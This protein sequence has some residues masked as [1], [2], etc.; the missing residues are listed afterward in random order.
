MPTLV[1]VW[2]VTTHAY[3]KRQKHSRKRVGAA[4][5]LSI[6]D[7]QHFLSTGLERC[8][9]DLSAVLLDRSRA[10]HVFAWGLLE[11]TEEIDS[12]L[13]SKTLQRRILLEFNNYLPLLHFTLKHVVSLQ[14]PHKAFHVG[15][16]PT[17]NTRVFLLRPD[18]V[19]RVLMSQPALG[20]GTVGDQVHASYPEFARANMS[21]IGFEM[22]VP[23]CIL[24]AFGQWTD[25]SLPAEAKWPSA[26][27]QQL[28]DDTRVRVCR[29]RE[30]AFEMEN[31]VVKLDT[32]GQE[33]MGPQGFRNM[34]S[35]ICSWA[36]MLLEGKQFDMDVERFQMELAV[37]SCEAQAKLLED[38]AAGHVMEDN[39][40]SSGKRFNIVFLLQ[41][42]WFAFDLKS[43]SS[44]RRALLQAC[45][46]MFPGTKHTFLQ[47]AIQSE[48]LPLPSQSVLAQ[49]RFFL[50]MALM[51]KMRQKH[52]NIYHPLQNSPH[53]C[54]AHGAMY[55]MADSS[56]QGGVNWL[57]IEYVRIDH[58]A[59][60]AS[61]KAAAQLTGVASRL[62]QAERAGLPILE[63]ELDVEMSCATML[64]SNLER[65]PMVPVGLGSGR[66]S[67]WHELHALYHSF[68]LEC[69]DP[70][71]LAELASSVISMT[72]DRGT[73]AGFAQAHPVPFNMFFPHFQQAH[74]V[75][76]EDA[77]GLAVEGPVGEDDEADEAPANPPVPANDAP[78]SLRSALPTPGCLH[79]VHNATRNMLRAMPHF[80]SK[81]KAGFAAVVD[82]LHSSYTRQRFVATCLT[83][84]EAHA[85]RILFASFQHTVVKWRFGTFAAVCKDLLPLE[86]PLRRYWSLASMRFHQ[87]G[88][89]QDAR[90]A[91]VA[92]PGNFGDG[93]LRGPNLEVAS[94]AIL[95]T[96]F[97]SYIHMIAEL[98]D[99]VGHVENW[100]QSCPCHSEDISEKRLRCAIKR[101]CPLRSLRAPELAADAFEPFLQELSALSAAAVML[102]HTRGCAVQDRVWILEDFE[103]G[104]QHLLFSFIMQTACWSQLPHKLC[105]IGHW[106]P[107][108]ARVHAAT[109]LRVWA[110]MSQEQKDASHQLSQLMLAHGSPLEQQLRDFVQGTSLDDLPELSRMA[111][112]LRFI[113]LCEKRIEG[114][115]AFVHKVLKKASNAGPVFISMAERM[116]LLIELSKEDV[117][118]MKSL[119]QA[120]DELYRPLKAVAALGLSGH[121]ELAPIIANVVTPRWNGLVSVWGTTHKYSKQ[122]KKVVYHLDEVSQYMDM[123]EIADHDHGSGPAPGKSSKTRARSE[124]HTFEEQAAFQKLLD[125]HEESRVYSISSQ[126]GQRFSSL[127]TKVRDSGPNKINDPSPG[128]S[129]FFFN[130]EA[131]A[132]LGET[133]SCASSSSV[134]PLPK[135]DADIQERHASNRNSDVIVFRILSLRPSRMKLPQTDKRLDLAWSDMAVSI[136]PVHE[137]ESQDR[138]WVAATP[139]VPT[140]SSVQV[141][142]KGGFS[143]VKVWKL[144]PK[145]RCSW[146]GGFQH[147]LPEPLDEQELQVAAEALVQAGAFPGTVVGLD[148]SEDVSGSLDYLKGHGLA[149]ISEAGLWQISQQGVSSLRM[150]YCMS[151]VEDLVNLE[152]SLPITDRSES[153]LLLFLKQQGWQLYQWVSKKGTA[154]PKPHPIHAQAPPPPNR[155][156]VNAGRVTVGQAYLAVLAKVVS[157]EPEFIVLCEQ[158]G[159]KAIPHLKGD[160]FYERLLEGRLKAQSDAL[161]FERDGGVP[162]AELRSSKKRTA[163]G[164]AAASNREKTPSAPTAPELE[165]G[166]DASPKPKPQVV[167]DAKRK[168]LRLSSA[169]SASAQLKVPAAGSGAS[170]SN[171]PAPGLGG[172]ALAP[173]RAPVPPA[174]ADVAPAV[175]EVPLLPPGSPERRVRRKTQQA[176]GPGFGRSGHRFGTFRLHESFRW[177]CVSFKYK[178]GSETVWPAYQVDCVRYDHYIYHVHGAR[179]SCSKT[180]GFDPDSDASKDDVLQRLKTWVVEGLTLSSR[181]AHKDRGA[182]LASRDAATLLTNE[183]LERHRPDAPPKIE[184]HVPAPAV[185]EAKAKPAARSKPKPKGIPKAKAA[186]HCAEDDASDSSTS[187]TSSTSD[188]SFVPGSSQSDS[189]DHVGPQM[190]K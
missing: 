157:Q 111:A 98:A 118:V 179:T 68:F 163:R 59:L 124:S 106:L 181:K 101:G 142:S 147:V 144:D 186:L 176:P 93:H 81:V 141:L 145:L 17:P 139:E 156:Y 149:S 152:E 138:M 62:T 22:W 86:L 175:P 112:R 172:L 66:A 131:D 65:R 5:L 42:L 4:A 38:I 40:H 183:E 53:I 20:G 167:A 169:A 16:R 119:A 63:E 48:R 83:T 31:Q 56:P 137:V 188:S 26:V 43:D 97:W 6:P 36:G 109:C 171:D 23:V 126:E 130:M 151:K 72:S 115:R 158:Q 159:L 24:S 127:L 50:D 76:E 173:A 96:T 55:V 160:K 162:A 7:V 92:G 34:G 100:F 140:A 143:S 12:V 78:L 77:L 180:M 133:G 21:Q 105:A 123:T 9:Y 117:T 134:L 25:A 64:W 29:A 146:G 164:S 11:L 166:P 71:L 91:D 47:E 27:L 153:A 87:A 30:A 154:D 33:I 46:L 177:G 84:P 58:C 132:G 19:Q 165:Q 1:P 80:E 178:K 10:G 67:M 121:P 73:E 52:A 107:D 189:A 113:P 110:N 103:C 51:V 95:S 37:Q 125:N 18:F 187:S 70:A 74:F 45:T 79:I 155:M 85:F 75:F 90:A 8:Q 108:V 69:G 128:N 14:V 44:L 60:M 15:L 116:P 41:A 54:D 122:V 82:V 136:L 89:G 88:Q 3:E 129:D 184:A 49:A 174:D 148:A 170:S 161:N 168:V 32:S 185:P 94:E 61:A 2:L 120:A 28:H 57:M 135:S 104:R 35:Q 102:N 182:D 39:I 114:R 150:A 190:F 99:F 13:N